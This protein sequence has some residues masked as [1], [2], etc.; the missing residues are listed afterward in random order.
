M[1]FAALLTVLFAGTLAVEPILPNTD[2]I[3]LLGKKNTLDSLLPIND[4]IIAL[5][6]SLGKKNVLPRDYYI[7]INDT[8]MA[9]IHSLGKKN[10]LPLDSYIKQINWTL[11]QPLLLSKKRDILQGS[12]TTFNPFI[13]S[14]RILDLVSIF[15]PGVD[16]GFNLQ[17]QLLQQLSGKRD[18]QALISLTGDGLV[19]FLPYLINSKKRDIVQGSSTAFNPWILSKRASDLAPILSLGGS[20][21]STLQQLIDQIASKRSLQSI[22]TIPDLG[23]IHFEPNLILSKKRD[24]VFDPFNTNPLIISKKRDILFDPLHPNV[25]SK[26][27]IW[28]PLIDILLP[29]IKDVV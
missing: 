17:Q 29:P 14:K 16:G 10:V 1:Y 5:I 2:W 24:V 23:I 20:G 28:N 27:N 26:K 21:G 9:L 6:H 12:S 15:S 13:L 8:L 7:T 18:S 22:L 4:T 19:P 25:V 11:F 3:H